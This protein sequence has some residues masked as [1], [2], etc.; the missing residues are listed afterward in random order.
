V[1]EEA[2]AAIRA[3]VTAV[4][5]LTVEFSEAK[6]FCG[7]RYL[8]LPVL[9]LTA[10]SPGQFADAVAFIERE[11]PAGVVYV[12]C[13]AGYSRSA[14]VV[15]AWLLA[16]HRATSPEDAFDQ[17]R[18]MRPSIVIRPEIRLAIRDFQSSLS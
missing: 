2:R 15:V 13:K 9:D 5:D 16:T 10:P 14:G 8:H 11:T 7:I 1:E 12:H 18:R 17:L 4:L 3:G 6:A